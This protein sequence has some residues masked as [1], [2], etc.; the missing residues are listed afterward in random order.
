MDRGSV[1]ID[2][3]QT[4][5]VVVDGMDLC[6]DDGTRWCEM[7]RLIQNA[8]GISAVGNGRGGGGDVE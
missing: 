2:R 7:I 1:P 5:C 4:K 6:R 8:I 3:S